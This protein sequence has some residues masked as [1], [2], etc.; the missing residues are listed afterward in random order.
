VKA[1]VQVPLVF[2]A[3]GWVMVAPTIQLYTVL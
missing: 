1:Q 3:Q 2:T